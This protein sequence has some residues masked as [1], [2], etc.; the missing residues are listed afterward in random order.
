MMSGSRGHAVRRARDASGSAN[1]WSQ[2]TGNVPRFH[3]VWSNW[4]CFQSFRGFA[5]HVPAWLHRCLVQPAEARNIIKFSIIF[6]IFGLGYH[7]LR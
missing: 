3:K 4:E 6:L 2:K 1:A 7:N 5:A